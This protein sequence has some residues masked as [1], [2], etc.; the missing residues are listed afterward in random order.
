MVVVCELLGWDLNERDA[1]II[2][3]KILRALQLL[4][5]SLPF[6]P[7]LISLLARW[8]LW[9]TPNPYNYYLYGEAL[10]EEILFALSMLQWASTDEMKTYL[11]SSKSA[12]NKTW[13]G[14]EWWEA[15]KLGERFAKLL[16]SYKRVYS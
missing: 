11:D 3:T 7:L 1:P 2:D 6:F 13:G 12:A 16:A 5:N 8:S 9:I 14:R 10:G 15:R 4:S